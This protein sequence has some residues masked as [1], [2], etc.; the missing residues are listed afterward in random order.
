MSYNVYAT[1]G[2]YMETTMLHVRVN[3]ELKTQAHEYLSK[4][5]LTLSDAVRVL[6]TRIVDEGGLPIALTANS[7]AYDTWF[8]SKVLEA[9]AQKDEV[10]FDE[11]MNKIEQKLGL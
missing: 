10:P 9:M 2:G 7:A 8:K 11:G 6:L 4:S 5:G 1:Q 3:N